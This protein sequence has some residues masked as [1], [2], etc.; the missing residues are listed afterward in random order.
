M[1]TLDQASRILRRARR[2]GLS[3]SPPLVAEL[4]SYLE[5][6]ARWNRR[7]NL[8]AL[9]VDPPSDE[10]IDR[11]IVEP[12]EAA[13]YVSLTA[14]VAVDVGSGGGSP[15]IPFKLA[16][17]ALRL[18]LI[19]SKVRKAAF[20]REAVRTLGLSDMEVANCRFEAFE[21]PAVDLITMRAVRLDRRLLMGV[22][23]I[24]RPE[25]RAFLFLSYNQILPPLDRSLL[26]VE[27]EHKLA[28]TGR[29]VILR[30]LP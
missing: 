30:R 1:A 27:S 7:M 9:A 3:P 4:E 28:G 10:A 14:R 29:L 16:V 8:T 18:A 11:L 23:A 13:R 12:L 22:R 5:L 19:E 2:V 21:S 25:G 6:L 17:P 15:G 26:S 20:L 24:L